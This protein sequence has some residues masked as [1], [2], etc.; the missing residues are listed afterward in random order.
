MALWANSPEI[1]SEYVQMYQPPALVH[2]SEKQLFKTRRKRL[3]GLPPGGHGC[4]HGGS[5]SSG[6]WSGP[7]RQIGFARRCLR[8]QRHRWLILFACV[9]KLRRLMGT[10]SRW[11]WRPSLPGEVGR[12]QVSRSRPSSSGA[13]TIS[14][15]LRLSRGAPA[16]RQ[17]SGRAGRSSPAGRAV[18]ITRSQPAWLEGR[19][20]CIAR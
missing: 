13:A 14:I 3:D 19:S 10:A 17:R 11:C 20:K 4:A 1:E 2:G 15:R 12:L 6:G 16:G 7:F 18:S 8:T 5:S 9:Q